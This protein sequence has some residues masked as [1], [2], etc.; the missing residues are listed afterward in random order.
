MVDATTFGR[1]GLSDWVPTATR[2]GEAECAAARLQ[3]S[4]AFH[5]R[6]FLLAE[7]RTQ[8]SLAEA[9]G[10]RRERLSR[11]LGGQV[12]VTLSDL[13]QILQA[14]RSSVA[15]VSW[16]STPVSDRA[17]PARQ[18]VASFLREQLQALEAPAHPQ[19]GVQP[20]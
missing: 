12:W 14:C 9:L 13:E 7:D 18:V 6:A 3:H 15:G 20:R 16:A 2:R 10:W 17:T 19:G 8:G 5:V 4:A 1:P 11:V